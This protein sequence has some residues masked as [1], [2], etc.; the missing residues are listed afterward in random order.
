MKS[1]AKPSTS[2]TVMPQAASE[3]CPNVRQ[4]VEQ[5]HH[6]VED[7]AGR[8]AEEEDGDGGAHPRLPDDGAEEGRAA[9]DQ[10]EQEQEAPARDLPLAS[11]RRDDA[12]ALGRVV[13]AEADD[14]RD[15]ELE[16]PARG[17]LPD[18]ETLREVVQADPGRDQHREEARRREAHRVRLLELGRGGR[19]RAEQRPAPVA[20]HPAL[21]ADQPHEAEP[22]PA[23]EQRA[24]ARRRRRTSSRGSPP[25]PARRR[26]TSRPRT[27][28][29]GCPSPSR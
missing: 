20:V 6:D 19:A 4:I 13:E 24:V 11:E 15:R 22:E 16:L 9:A 2:P 25:R 21:V 28:R 23:E 17:R 29:R 3:A 12:E 26:S 5:L 7:R 8:E 18:R 10:P 14:Q 27:G 1:V